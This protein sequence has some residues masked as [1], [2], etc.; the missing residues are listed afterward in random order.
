MDRRRALVASAASGGGGGG[1][2]YCELWRY[3]PRDGGYIYV[4]TAT[5]IIPTQMTWGDTIGLVDTEELFGIFSYDIVPYITSIEETGISADYCPED[6]IT[7]DDNIE[8]G[9]T[10]KFLYG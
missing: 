8:V 4:R 3:S 2:F 1:E 7:I 10:Y 5:F 6:N 9:K